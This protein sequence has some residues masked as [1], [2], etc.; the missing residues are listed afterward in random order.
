MIAATAFLTFYQFSDAEASSKRRMKRCPTCQSTYTDDS[1]RFC[2][3]DGATLLSMSGSSGGGPT[4]PDQEKTLLINSRERTNEPPQTEILPAVQ[5][6][7]ASPRTPQ[8]T[9]QS[10]LPTGMGVQ[11]RV[12]TPQRPKS[13]A[14]I[15]P[16]TIA[17]TVLVLAVVGLGAWLLLSDKQSAANGNTRVDRQSRTTNTQ[18]TSSPAA[19]AA[20]TA[21]SPTPTPSPVNVAAVREEVTDALNGWADSSTQRDIERQMSYYADTLDVY[22]TKTNVS[23]SVVRMDRQRAYDTFSTLDIELSNVQITPDATAQRATVVLDKTWSFEGEEK[24]TSG[25]VQQELRLAKIDG[26]WRITGEK[27]LQVYYVNR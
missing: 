18:T 12:T 27:D 3:Q 22:Y 7:I 16:L 15:I 25:S 11:D 6:T 2:L 17:A 5:P 21:A 19:S 26:R 4:V 14:L 9:P 8:T 24:S 23:A 13:N 10:F 1:L 20:P